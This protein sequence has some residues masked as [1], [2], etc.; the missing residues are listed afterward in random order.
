MLHS[1]RSDRND[2]DQAQEALRESQAR[3]L[4]QLI[5]SAPNGI[6]M[7]D[8]SGKIVLVNAQIEKSFGYSREELLGQPIEILVPERYHQHHSSY[9]AGFSANPTTRP[10]GV[11]R[12]LFG[13]RKDGNEF[14]VEIGLSPLETYQ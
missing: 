13:R 7:V 2:S 11:G 1:E 4:R 6:V 10:M 3:Q 12:D 5:E 14:P 9:R 8:Q